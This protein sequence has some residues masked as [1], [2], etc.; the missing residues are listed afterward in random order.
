MQK[1]AVHTDVDHFKL[2]SSRIQ[3][4]HTNVSGIYAVQSAISELKCEQIV[5]IQRQS[6]YN[7][8]HIGIQILTNNSATQVYGTVATHEM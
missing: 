7:G 2:L 1:L 4:Y 3:I 8:S 5:H 6:R